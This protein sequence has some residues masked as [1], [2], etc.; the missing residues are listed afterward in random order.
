MVDGRDPDLPLPGRSLW[1]CLWAL[2][3]RWVEGLMAA[4]R[5]AAEPGAWDPTYGTASVGL[6]ARG[7]LTPVRL[8]A[9]PVPR[10]PGSVIRGGPLR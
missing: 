1:L 10:R 9:G 3:L 5:F 7:A 8:R 4:P 2:V 6:L